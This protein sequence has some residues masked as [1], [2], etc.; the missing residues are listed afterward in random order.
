L[1]QLKYCTFPTNCSSR[2]TH[3]RELNS[4]RVTVTL[5]AILPVKMNNLA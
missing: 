5:K 4:L 2:V 1:I 3:A